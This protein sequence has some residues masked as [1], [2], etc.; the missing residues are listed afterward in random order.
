MDFGKCRRR[1]FPSPP[2]LPGIAAIQD[3]QLRQARLLFEP[4]RL[5]SKLSLWL[6]PLLARTGILQFAMRKRIRR[7]AGGTVPVR[8]TV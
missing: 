5:A 3:L 7:F 2:A 8:L 4:N 6:L 1:G